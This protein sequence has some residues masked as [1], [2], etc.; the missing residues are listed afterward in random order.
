MKT[1][2]RGATIFIFFF[3]IFFNGVLLYLTSQRIAA[4]KAKFN[5]AC[6]NALLA[7]L[8]QYDRIKG[9]DTAV[10]PKNALIT[11]TLDELTVNR[12]DSQN[13]AVRSP[14]S[15]LYA[16]RVN[17][18]AIGAIINRPRTLSLDLFFFGKLYKKALDSF[19]VHSGY[20][21]D[22]FPIPFKPDNANTD[23]AGRIRKA[24]SMKRTK[25]YPFSTSPQR[26]FFYP[27]ALIFAEHKYDNRFFR[28]E[29]LWPMLAF[30]FILLISNTALV[31]VYRTI[32]R[33]KRINEIKTDFI[34]NITHEM[35][36]PL[37]IASASL[38]GLQHHI[39]A[40]ERTSFFLDTGKRHLRVLNDFV[41]RIVDA[42]MQDVS[43]LVLKKEN[44]DLP[45]LFGE[46]IKS[47]SVLQGKP[48][49]FQLT[50]ATYACIQGDRL[51]LETVFYNIIDNA[52][53][54]SNGPVKVDIDIAETGRDCIIK[55]KDNGM[56]IAPQHI[57]NIFKK[58]FRVPQGDAQAVKGFGLGLYYVSNIIKKHSGNITVHSTLQTGTQF[59]ITLPKSL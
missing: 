23:M 20:H 50:G 54:Y 18:A 24:W 17:P 31:F 32:R 36:T 3:F 41:E 12:L 1:S 28:N 51:Y 59:I 44:I 19:K 30:F 26:I 52:V 48:V 43:D 5:T 55:I 11:Y 56:G 33:Q 46:L 16:L 42:A 37:T 7:T 21:L 29:L 8:F 25:G 22:T 13:I 49:S 45:V 34:N 4:A 40:T 14:T 53:K 6:T 15:R 39:T 38:D 27:T 2:A 47:H 57:K 9:T 10:T 58:F 35:K